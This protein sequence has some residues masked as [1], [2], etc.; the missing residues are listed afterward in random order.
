MPSVV[1]LLDHWAAIQPGNTLFEFRHSHGKSTERHTYRSFA[2]RTRSHA[3]H[4]VGTF[5]L[6]AGDRVLL[7]YPPGLEGIAALL[8][9]ARAGLIGVPVAVPR[10]ADDAAVRR[11][12]AIADDCEAA[13]L[14]SV[15]DLGDRLHRLLS[16]TAYRILSTD[17]LLPSSAGAIGCGSDVL[18]L[19]YTS[20]S[21]GRPRGVL[22]SNG[23]VIANADATLDHKPLGVSWLP[24]HHDMGLIGYYLFPI[25]SGGTS[26][27]FSPAEFLRKPA[28]W[29]RTLSDVRATYTSAPNFGYEYCLR[30]GKIGDDELEGVDLSALRVMM[31]ASE[32]ARAGTIRRFHHRFA[33]YGLRRSACTVAYG[34]AENTLTVS[35]GGRKTLRVDRIALN[36]RRRIETVSGRAACD[37][38]EYASCGAPARGV[39]VAICDTETS[40]PV[41]ER[42]VG[43][44]C[45]A[46][47]SVT[48]GY[49]NGDRAAHP[50]TS[51]V[52]GQ[53]EQ[54]EPRFVR[55]GDLGFLHAGELYVCGRIKDLIIVAGANFFPDD[56]EAA[57]AAGGAAVRARGICAFQ[58]GEGR[59]VMLVE[60]MR[61]GDLP[62]PA[63]LANDVRRSCGLLPDAVHV[64]PPGTI[65]LTTSGKIA[66]A[67]TR[68][69][70]ES[71]QVRCVASYQSD[72]QNAAPSSDD[73]YDWRSAMRRSFLRQR[74][75]EE[76][77]PLAES[78]LDSV[79]LT[80]LQLELEGILRRTGFAAL[81]EIL[82]APL[83]QRLSLRNLLEALAPLDLGPAKG[84]GQAAAKLVE[85]RSSL[86]DF[87]RAQMLADCARPLP[88]PRRSRSRE[89]R[90]AEAILLTGAT[91]FFGPFLLHELLLQTEAP[92]IV[93]VRAPTPERAMERVETALE[94]ARV[95]TPALRRALY[96]RVR[97]FVGDLALAHWG[98]AEREWIALTRSVREIFHNGAC[99]N[100]VMTYEAMRNANVEGTRTALTLALESDVQAL[101]LISSTFVFGWTRKGM[102][103]ESDCNAEMQGLDFGYAQSKW[104]AEQQAHAARSRGL[105]VRVYRPSLIS[106]STRG[107]GDSNDVAV[108]VLAFMIR[109]GIAVDSPNQV[110]IVAADVV[111]RNIV[112]I[113]RLDGEAATALHAT[114][115]DYYS[116]GDLTR[117]ITRRFG[118]TFVY[119]DVPGFIDELNRRCS[120]DDPLYPLLD[121]FNRSADKIAVMQLKRYSSAL[122]Q[123]ER[124]RLADPRADPS[125][126]ET[127]AY[128]VGYLLEQ[129]L[130]DPIIEPA[131]RRE[132]ASAQARPRTQR[133]R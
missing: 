99:V 109:H 22:V 50:L 36:S 54:F 60:P 68:S 117:A 21:T 98:M 129:R 74:I 32:P 72:R 83:L 115:D 119:Y 6:H 130:I 113:S 82:D 124:A 105:D 26:Y 31:N 20:G 67:E 30:D 93:I 25:V 42:I 44:I 133:A 49:W 85:F 56:L 128:L 12:R 110:S 112:G 73:M 4:L 16:P 108:R 100:Y 84:T 1:E 17:D 41:E 102:L 35:H 33:R 62:D 19:Q 122:Y 96:G 45:V 116:M 87:V 107:A 75:S 52:E 48:R 47:D 103:L 81:A 39:H 8:G 69:L 5:G 132:G 23:N 18:F 28:S 92:V 46:G 64:V 126:E 71:G 77:L 89:T 131:H 7:A 80:E 55:T 91:G 86:D 78:G 114:V 10:S 15:A 94:T 59:V 118:Y 76:Q 111:A 121:F 9:C 38:V 65:A 14:L 79:G 95:M 97:P 29:I 40:R 127:A 34:L 88:A 106:V 53:P 63:S 120:A 3:A 27:G 24:Q 13:A 101:H 57:I 125:V 66:R 2:E 58:T 11:L 61:I 123:R 90:S 104:V 51:L 43:E 70:F 37:T